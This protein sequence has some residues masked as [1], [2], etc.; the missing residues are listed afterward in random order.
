MVEKG[1]LDARQ[2]HKDYIEKIELVFRGFGQ[3]RDAFFKALMGM[4]GR[5]LRKKVVKI[6][7][8]TRLKFGGPRGKKPRRL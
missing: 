4:E 1:L 2:R 3:G 5:G 6:S 8:S 7:D